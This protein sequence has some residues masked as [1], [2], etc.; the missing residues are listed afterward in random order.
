MSESLLFPRII[1]TGGSGFIGTSAVDYAIDQN[2]NFLNCDL[3]TPNKKD[4]EKYW[5]QIEIRNREAFEKA[6]YS[7]KPTHILSAA[8]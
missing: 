4:H 1:I 3:K 7:F 5:Q 6:V 8:T 2:Y